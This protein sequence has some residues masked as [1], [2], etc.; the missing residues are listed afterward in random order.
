MS[1]E[2]REA[3]VKGLRMVVTEGTAYN[4]FHGC[5]VSV[6][7]KT[8]SAQTSGVYTNGVCVAYAPYEKPRIAIACVIE[9]AGSGANVAQAVRKVVD[10]Y[11]ENSQVLDM[12]TGV[13]TK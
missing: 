6:A 11:F 5:K 10:S 9:K 12:Q 8:G 7:A 2:N 13:L 3:I 4:A 1:E